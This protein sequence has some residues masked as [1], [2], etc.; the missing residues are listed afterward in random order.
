[1]GK[2]NP[3]RLGLNPLAGLGKLNSMQKAI[4]KKNTPFDEY[5]DVIP[6]DA[7]LPYLL[8]LAT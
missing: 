5:T 2:K 7:D 8:T 6:L 1:M 3:P 4:V